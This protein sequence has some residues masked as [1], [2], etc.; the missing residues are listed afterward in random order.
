MVQ[1]ANS[2]TKED[3]RIWLVKNNIK[4]NRLA[5][6]LGY[7]PGTVHQVVFRFVGTDRTPKSGA[8]GAKILKDLE[9]LVSSGEYVPPPHTPEALAG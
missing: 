8:L 4:L 2:I 5:R 7:E 3:L 1:S 6:D 9:S